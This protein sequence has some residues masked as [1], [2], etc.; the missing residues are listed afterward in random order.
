M[1]IVMHDNYVDSKHVQ[2]PEVMTKSI[3]AFYACIAAFL[4]CIAAAV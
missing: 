3:A 4:A 2:A 1:H